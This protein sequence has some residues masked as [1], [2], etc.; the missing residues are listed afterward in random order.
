[1]PDPTSFVDLVNPLQ[2][3]RSVP[4]FSR[5]STH[6]LVQ[7]PWAP[8]SWSL[9]TGEAPCLFQPDLPKLRGIRAVSGVELCPQT[10]PLVTAPE[11]R[12]SAYR[13]DKSVVSP[14][15][16]KTEFLRYR[17]GVDLA[18]TPTGAVMRWT[19][20]EGGVGRLLV[21]VAGGTA[22][23][24]GTGEVRGQGLG[25][26]FVVVFDKPVARCGTQDGIVW[27]EFD[28]PRGGVVEARIGVGTQ[29]LDRTSTVEQ[30]S[31]QAA[32]EWNRLLG[33]FAVE[34]GTDDQ[35]RTFYSCLYRVLCVP[36]GLLGDNARSVYPLM[37]L[38]YGDE[39][40][41]TLAAWVT[42]ADLHLPTGSLESVLAEAL[43]QGVRFDQDAAWKALKLR[44]VE[45]APGSVSATLDRAFGD[46]CV[47]RL[48]QA[49]GKAEAPLFDDKAQ[50]WQTLFDPSMGFFRPREP[51][52]SWTEGFNPLAWGGAFAQ[53]S[54]WQGGWAVPHDPE[55]LMAAL[56]GPEVTLARLDTLLALKPFFHL[57][58]HDREV[59]AMTQ[60]ATADFGQ[61]AHS[62]AVTHGILWHYALAG[63]PDKTERLTRRVMEELY[64]PGVDGFCG[65][66]ND[67]ELAAWY[68]WA[69]LGLYP[70]CPGSGEYVLGSPLF[71]RV[72][73]TTAD[74]RSLVIEAPGNGPETPVVRKRTLGNVVLRE[75]RV[76]LA[77]LFDLGRLTCEMDS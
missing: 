36:R 25:E 4:E 65:D 45:A 59:P 21:E 33:R 30:V 43:V 3:T 67:G 5:G 39:L 71:P 58:S 29:A 37:A 27:A 34:G 42:S 1:M 68:L 24:E 7:W 32:A 20:A 38:A 64:G 6:P 51:D 47:A 50:R 2:G 66:A 54:A 41:P 57:G 28:L 15:R 8:V 31:D 48:A 56:G 18:P 46:W 75:P 53:G 9:V 60:M 77:D 76:S 62:L 14:H 40:A 44:A 10:G 55:G 11:R 13:L 17:V 16:L 63:R 74:G 23:C 69:A 12:A 73:V 49:W 72:T 52:G 61:Y 26:P 22:R 35:R 70:L 19:F